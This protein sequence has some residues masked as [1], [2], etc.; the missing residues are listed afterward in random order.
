M[1]PTIQLLN[2]IGPH[3]ILYLMGINSMAKIVWSSLINV[4]I[5]KW[6]AM[7]NLSTIHIQAIKEK[8]NIENLDGLA[9]PPTSTGQL[10][11]QDP[12]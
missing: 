1:I 10:A 8:E 12:D 4:Q 6:D 7:G 2:E 3:I 9:L 5:W 11:A